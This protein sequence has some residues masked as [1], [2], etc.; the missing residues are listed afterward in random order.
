MEKDINIL[1]VGDVHGRSFWKEPVKTVLENSDAEV[2]FLGDYLDPYPDEFD[3][4]FELDFQASTK[5]LQDAI[6]NFK[7]IIEL[8]K[9]Y[10]DRITLLLGNH[11]CGYAISKDICNCRTDYLHF[12][13]I[14]NV[15]R[16]NKTLFQIAKEEDINGK[17]F[18]FSH[19]G[20]LRK[21]FTNFFSHINWDKVNPVDFFNNAWEVGD[22]KVLERLGVYDRC[23][24]SCL[25]NK[26]GSPVWSDI[27]MWTNVKPDET[28]GFNIVGHTQQRETPIMFETIA[29]L[30]CRKC[31]YVNSNGDIADYKTD[32]VIEETIKPTD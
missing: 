25:G 9:Q 24:G 5:Y 15:F 3:S 29:C 31:F 23:R 18:I 28:F 22:F 17:H 6:D 2:V 32:K 7:E 8:K 30:D 19:A 26:Y 10:P 1:I 11:D 16:E 12:A 4:N 21:Y 27:R 13:D 20:M 14:M